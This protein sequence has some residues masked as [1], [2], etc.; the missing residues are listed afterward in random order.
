MNAKREEEVIEKNVGALNNKEYSH[1]AR[2]F[3]TN[4][5]ELSRSLQSKF[6]SVDKDI[7]IES[8]NIDKNFAIKEL[9]E[10]K[11]CDITRS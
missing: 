8:I 7:N 10:N 4:I 5:M 3:F 2:K 11:S 9:I 1:I 6:I